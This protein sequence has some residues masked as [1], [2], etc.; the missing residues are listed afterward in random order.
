MRL[1]HMVATA[2]LIASGHGPP[3]S[4]AF[5][6]FEELLLD[7]PRRLEPMTRWSRPSERARIGI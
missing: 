1:D 3:E 4:H 2:G 7:L 5:Y 6:L